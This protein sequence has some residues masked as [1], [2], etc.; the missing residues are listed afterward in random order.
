MNLVDICDFA[1]RNKNINVKLLLNHHVQPN[2][3]YEA[4]LCLFVPLVK[5][6]TQQFF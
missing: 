6:A 5:Y 4:K 1:A 3:K 2:L